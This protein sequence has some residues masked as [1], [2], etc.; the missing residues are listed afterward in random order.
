MKWLIR[1]N[2]GYGD[3]IDVVEADTEEKA[4]EEAYDEWRAAAED[5]ADYQAIPWTQELEDSYK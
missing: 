5:S 1:W 4:E 3:H 2:I